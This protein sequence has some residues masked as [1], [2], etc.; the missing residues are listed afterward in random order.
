M[1]TTAQESACN[2]CECKL[3]DYESLYEL[4]DSRVSA[5]INDS[6]DARISA[7][8]KRMVDSTVNEAIS[9]TVDA[10]ARTLSTSFTNF[11]SSQQG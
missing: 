10:S 6:M 4:I 7:S 2:A 11:L 1:V 9:E 8:V 3:S 5:L